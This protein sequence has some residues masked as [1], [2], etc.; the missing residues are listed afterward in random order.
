MM[1]EDMPRG[2]EPSNKAEAIAQRTQREVNQ[3]LQ[4]SEP[5]H[6]I[7]TCLVK[8]A[9]LIGGSDSVSSILILDRNGLLRNG[10][11]P[12]LPFDYLTAIDGL[13]PHPMLGTCASVAATGKIVITKDF[14]SDDKWAELRHL[15]LAIGFVSAW[16]AP[17]KTN[18]G[19]ILGTFG[20]Y[21]RT[22]REPSQQEISSVQL[23][24][25]MAAKALRP[26]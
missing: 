10:C 2:H 3:M 11:S 18:D 26:F 16:S 9:E 5:Q 12:H 8:A 1:K 6:K 13:K 23:L 24:A 14:K 25:D 15:P 7:L 19:K 22:N 17:I 21:F 4:N 20:T